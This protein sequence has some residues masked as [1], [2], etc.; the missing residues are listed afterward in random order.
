M[1][2]LQF[3]NEE[4]R[5]ETEVLR[6]QVCMIRLLVILYSDRFT[7]PER[8]SVGGLGLAAIYVVIDGGGSFVGDIFAH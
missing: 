1:E 3:D 7:R 5:H 2:S 8:F 6:N 4:M